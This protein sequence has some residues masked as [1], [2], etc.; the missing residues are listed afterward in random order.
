MPLFF[1]ELKLP[2]PDINLNVSGGDHGFQTGKTMI[3]FEPILVQEKPDLVI[4][5]GDVNSTIACAMVASKKNI[6]V[7]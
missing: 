5:V 2:K 6:K 1:R 4:V 3:E 7:A